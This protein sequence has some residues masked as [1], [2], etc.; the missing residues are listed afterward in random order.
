MKMYPVASSTL[1]F[2]GK[3]PN[4]EQRVDLPAPDAPIIRMALYLYLLQRILLPFFNNSL[5]SKSWF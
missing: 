3:P 1:A 5:S 2:K 4:K